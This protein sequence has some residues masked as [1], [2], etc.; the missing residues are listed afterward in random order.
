MSGQAARLLDA[1]ARSGD[2]PWERGR[3]ELLT[4]FDRQQLD[5]LLGQLVD[6]G[7]LRRIRRGLYDVVRADG[8]TRSGPLSAA[9]AL[10][11]P[12]VLSHGTALDLHELSD[13]ASREIVVT[14]TSR[15]SSR[16][17]TVEGRPVRIVLARP[18]R[19]FGFVAVAPPDRAGAPLLAV[20]RGAVPP[21]AREAALALC[22]LAARGGDVAA[23]A[24]EA[25]RV[26]AARLD[27]VGL[28]ARESDVGEVLRVLRGKAGREVVLR[29]LREELTRPAPARG[30]WAVHRALGALARM[31]ETD[32]AAF[33]ALGRLCRDE[34][35]PP[36]RRPTSRLRRVRDVRA[37]MAL[38]T[39]AEHA[40]GDIESVLAALDELQPTSVAET[41]TGGPA[42]ERALAA[43]SNLDQLIEALRRGPDRTIPFVGAGLSREAGYPT[44]SGLL[45]EMAE[46]AGV[47]VDVSDP[48]RYPDVAQELR[49]VLGETE[50]VRF[51]RRR[52]PDAFDGTVPAAATALAEWPCTLFLTSNWDGVLAKAL[53]GGASVLHWTQAAAALDAWKTGR[54]ALLRVHGDTSRMP[55]TGRD[56]A[57]LV[58]T[59]ADY[60][61]LRKS[62]GRCAREYREAMK[63]LLAT[64]TFVFV[65]FGLADPDLEALL[66]ANARLWGPLHG[67]HYVILPEDL[68]DKV[69]VAP[70][71]LRHVPYDASGGDHT[72][73][74]ALLRR[75]ARAA[76]RR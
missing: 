69:A 60:D 64:G 65:G 23:G 46:R 61:H 50:Y 10:V 58:L 73:L 24:D 74:V 66:A 5:R 76:V 42:D 43:S 34:A 59:S 48:V 28:H 12:A 36:E 11:R 6:R 9:L 16:R 3:I 33:A 35:I 13:V 25:E 55:A 32:D 41:R 4:G 21:T 31:A 47:D 70:G 45:R 71:S 63:N 62:R 37:T 68:A 67:P 52:V 27:E 15:T 57:G 22:R 29:L 72:Q 19:F 30:S 51:L 14:T 56:R 44:W 8:T 53:G 54:R 17:R 40:F 7:W 1:V 38:S 20:V 39:R 2:G 26:L 49:D 75:L 18:S